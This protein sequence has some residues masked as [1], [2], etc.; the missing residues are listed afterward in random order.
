M[1]AAGP[2]GLLSDNLKTPEGLVNIPADLFEMRR[3]TVG[4][5]AVEIQRNVIAK[6]VLELGA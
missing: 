1:H 6:R 5:G 4:S 3:L 2:L